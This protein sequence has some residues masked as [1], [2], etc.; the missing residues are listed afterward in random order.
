VAKIYGALECAGAGG[1]VL[2]TAVFH[3]PLLLEPVV[4]RILGKEV[5]LVLWGADVLFEKLH[6]LLVR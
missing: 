1:G 2:A 3:L 5:E 6:Q 4:S